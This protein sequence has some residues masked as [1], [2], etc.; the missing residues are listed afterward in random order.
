MSDIIGRQASI[1][2]TGIATVANGYI[3]DSDF[4]ITLDDTTRFGDVAERFTATITGGR[5]TVQCFIDS[6]TTPAI[7]T[8]TGV[9]VTVTLA[10]GR[11]YTI[12]NGIIESVSTHAQ[13]NQG[14]PVQVVRYGIRVTAVS[15]GVQP[16][17]AA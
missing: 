10:S 6:G 14:S 13:A 2:G 11:T 16:V 12:T 17:I 8:G 5:L 15:S 9:V 1:S 4:R 7:P 3:I